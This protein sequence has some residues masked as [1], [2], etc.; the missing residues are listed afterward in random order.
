MPLRLPTQD[1]LCASEHSSPSEHATESK[2]GRAYSA[3]FELVALDE[4]REKRVKG[5]IT[6]LDASVSGVAIYLQPQT[7]PSLK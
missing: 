3:T 5:V 6:A 2:L 4:M 1:G 7:G